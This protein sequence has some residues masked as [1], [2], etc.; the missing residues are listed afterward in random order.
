MIATQSIPEQLTEIYFKNEPWHVF[1]MSY[2]E[3]LDYHTRGYNNGDIH[4]YEDNG[5]VLGYYERHCVFNVCFLDNIYIKDGHRKGRVFHNLYRH[6]F[7]TL[8]KNITHIMGEKQ[9]TNGTMHKVKVIRRRW[10][11][12]N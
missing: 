12:H 7:A 1:K 4:I 9:K 10:D 2:Q 6:F 11:G 5:E 8:P 3:A